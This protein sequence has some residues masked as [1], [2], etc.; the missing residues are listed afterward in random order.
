MGYIHKGNPAK[1]NVSDLLGAQ[2]SGVLKPALH[3]AAVP[4]TPI[5][6][7]SPSDAKAQR[8]EGNGILDSRAPR[9]MGRI[10]P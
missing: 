1:H 3:K 4:A 9:P 2:W 5:Q 8:T 6:D 7:R 10:G